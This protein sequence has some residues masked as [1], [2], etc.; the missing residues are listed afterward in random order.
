MMV[1]SVEHLEQGV[2]RTITQALIA[3]GLE[4]AAAA[5]R[6]STLCAEGTTYLQDAYQRAWANARGQREPLRTMQA[7]Q[8]AF[9]ALTV[10]AQRDK[11]V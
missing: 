8:V 4:T 1:P 7:Y 5:S 2:C 11:T 10:W 3:H 6:A 9:A